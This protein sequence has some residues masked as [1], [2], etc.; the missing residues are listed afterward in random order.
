MN[1]HPRYSKS[2]KKRNRKALSRSRLASAELQYGELEAKLPLDATFAHNTDSDVLTVSGFTPDE[3]VFV[4]R[5][6]DNLVF[7]LGNGVFTTPTAE[8]DEVMIDGGTLTV[9][10]NNVGDVNI[11]ELSSTSVLTFGGNSDFGG[12]E[13]TIN[14]L[15]GYSVEQFG[16]GGN[17]SGFA[18]GELTISSSL[19]DDGSPGA[20]PGSIINLF[21]NRNR[22]DTVSATGISSFNYASDQSFTLDTLSTVGTGLQIDVEGN[23]VNDGT[24]FIST[25]DNNDLTIESVNG[26]GALT[27]DI[28]G[29]LG[30]DS[31]LDVETLT[32]FVDGDVTRDVRDNSLVAN[33]LFFDVDGSIAVENL[34]VA[35]ISGIV[36]G[37]FTITDSDNNFTNLTDTTITADFFPGLTV[38]GDLD[39]TMR[40]TSLT[41]NADAPLQLSLLD[42]I[43]DSPFLDS[44]ADAGT[45][46]FR[47]EVL[48]G[49]NSILLAESD[50]NDF[51][52]VNV[53]YLD[54]ESKG[55]F[56]DSG[57]LRLMRYNALEFSDS[58]SIVVDN[59]IANFIPTDLD[60]TGANTF[61]SRVRIS[62]GRSLPAFEDFPVLVSN[63]V[64]SITITGQ[65]EGENLLLQAP[66]IF[67]ASGA[68]ID[69]NHLF[70]G[71]DQEIEGRANFQV[72]ADSLTD[73]S[74]NAFDS[75]DVTTQQ[76]LNI[77]AG[78][79]SPATAQFV[80]T[81]LGN[82]ATGAA[83]T[84]DTLGSNFDTE[85]ALFDINGILLAQ[86]DDAGIGFFNE[87]QLTPVGLA[88]GT[89]FIALAGFSSTFGDGFSAEG[90]F[91]SG[92]YTLNLNGSPVSGNLD[93]T[94]VVFFSFNVG[95]GPTLAPPLIAANSE[96][97]TNATAG[98]FARISSTRLNFDVPF[99]TRKLSADVQTDVTQSAGAVVLIDDLQIEAKRV[100]LDNTNN[101]FERIAVIGDG[102][103]DL[104]TDGIS[105]NDE[106]VLVIRDQGTL[107]IAS[108]DNLPIDAFATTFATPAVSVVVNGISIDGT[109]DIETGYGGD[110]TNPRTGGPT[111]EQIGP[112]GRV[113]QFDLVPGRTDGVFRDDNYD[114]SVRPAYFIEFIYD[115]V[116]PLEIQ[117]DEFERRDPETVRN[118]LDIELGLYNEAG[119][120]LA[121]D[122]D[123]ANNEL[124]VLS[125]ADIDPSFLVNGNLPAGRYYVAASAFATEFEDGFVVN[126]ANNQTGTLNVTIS[127]GALFVAPEVDRDL[128]QAPDAPLIVTGGEDEGDIEDGE[129]DGSVILSA[130][131]DGEILL[132]ETDLNDVRQLVVTNAIGVE[133]T[134]ADDV[135]FVSNVANGLTFAQVSVGRA[136]AGGVLTLGDFAADEA[137]LQADSGIITN[138]ELD[139]RRLLIGGADPRDSGGDIAIIS[140]NTEELAFQFVS[141]PNN[142]LVD[143][144]GN[145]VLD[146]DGNVISLFDTDL[147]LATAQDLTVGSFEFRDS[148]IL[149]LQSRADE[150]RLQAQSL[151]VNGT[152]EAV[153][154]LVVEVDGTLT[155][156]AD[157]DTQGIIT[158]QLYFTG[159]SLDLSQSDNPIGQIS[160]ATDGDG[161]DI[162]L[163]SSVATNVAILDNQIDIGELPTSDTLNFNAANTNEGATTRSNLDFNVLRL[164]QDADSVLRGRVLTIETTGIDGILPGDDEPVDPVDPDGPIVLP[165]GPEVDNG[166]LID[167]DVDPAIAGSFAADI[168]A[169]NSA[170]FASNALTFE[171]LDGTLI[172]ND[173]I[174][175]YITY[176]QVGDTTTNLAST[177]ITQIATLI[178]D[179]VV[180]SRGTFDGPNGLVTWIATSRFDDG[181]PT[182]FSTLEFEA[183]TG[184]TLGDIQIISYL[185]EDI[186]GVGDDFLTTTGIPGQANFR[187]FTLDG[188]NRVGFSHGG[189]YSNDGTNQI[190]ATYDG[191]AADQ[192]NEL[193]NQIITNTQ[194]F[195]IGGTIDLTDL[196]VLDDPDFS[197]A[198]G[199][200]DVTT[201]FSWSTVAD[202]ANST[203]TTF[204]EFLPTVEATQPVD[205]VD[206]VDPEVVGDIIL[207]QNN[208]ISQLIIPTAFEVTFNNDRQFTALEVDARSTID[209]SSQAGDIV[210]ETINTPFF[211]TLDAAD[212]VRDTAPLDG[213]RIN[214]ATLTVNAG[215][216]NDESVFNGVLLQTNVDSADIN[217]ASAESGEVII[218]EVSGI[219]FGEVVA[220]RGDIN[221]LA[222]GAISADRVTYNAADADNEILF[223]AGGEAS[224]VV[225]GFVDARLGDVRLF[226]TDDVFHDPA[227]ETALVRGFD[228]FTFV[229]NFTDDEN[230][231]IN[232]NTQ[233]ASVTAVVGRFTDDNPAA[234]NIVIDEVDALDVQFAKTRFG[235]IDITSGQNLVARFVQAEGV[236]VGDA[237]TL[238]TTGVGGDI[239]PDRVVSRDG[240]GAITFN[241]ADDIRDFQPGDNVMVIGSSVNLQ[242]GNNL[243][244]GF[245]GI[246]LET[247]SQQI[248]AQIL[249]TE[250]AQLALRNTGSVSITDTFVNNGSINVVN[251]NGALAAL[252]L[253]SGGEDESRIALMTAGIGA[254]IVIGSVIAAD[255]GEVALVSADDI[256]DS[257]FADDLFIEADFLVATSNNNRIDTFDGIVLDA[258]VNGVISNQPNGGENVI[259]RR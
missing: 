224:D 181:T 34:R 85:L 170:M 135:E 207:D 212:D 175:A 94:E 64:G 234:G 108:L 37:N 163:L 1:N 166:T 119:D 5:V 21:G 41:Q 191:W 179:D 147:A 86:N 13:I 82:V 3:T 169:G 204:L 226:A 56:T 31:I 137:L 178:A 111:A 7:Q 241:A 235:S 26:V 253:R 242:A 125:L 145:V 67:D 11:R 146:D 158:P 33:Q 98:E 126:T 255:G 168:G 217:I 211:V 65:I 2:A 203:V 36:D 238:T 128:T 9:E 25:D 101:D 90:G 16:S 172:S 107:Q 69:T 49:T 61:D 130:L 95:T 257:N 89:Y 109:V 103:A 157:A 223:N 55:F 68:D 246:I 259:R 104:F 44:D 214:A 79:Y 243:Q 60:Q 96:V 208:S 144:D 136:G 197:P 155:A 189:F 256:F 73:L 258:A 19:P 77:V 134:D 254:D 127:N 6:G 221:V 46:V 201:A 88:D 63:Q 27:L 22:I 59:L 141:D 159:A 199:P 192:F 216:D 132:A 240:L 93:F 78:E 121:V 165:T 193:Q 213:N 171:Q 116:S 81:D 177:T 142:V 71:G 200:N 110:V 184:T 123:D 249:G 54:A 183:E 250:F 14:G 138:G 29:S 237:V 164:T 245:N 32:L 133:F 112:T 220:G 218:R 187:A 247:R 117:S 222:G 20:I 239:V 100:V 182:L 143:E 215:N 80:A 236:D 120:L 149:L 252:D 209:L 114:G 232:L 42:R 105:N 151:T 186:Q 47:V 173:L 51:G 140:P 148:G 152:L 180:E 210:V 139:I 113:E 161:G 195:S 50:S 52:S 91:S 106:D 99:T 72:S 97:F 18:A 38:N 233:V 206:P 122:D 154:K 153:T 84:I 24:A 30:L 174:F 43:I 115:G 205:P 231:G 4:N 87:S 194:D 190:N 17:Q 229:R 66:G 76:E 176:I 202:Q 70:L 244:D 28:D 74:V 162:Q 196:P 129:P 198:F 23:I 83:V 45:A 219:D 118:V 8:D 53:E 57:V 150:I 167:N 131:A 92:S 228:L 12:A 102:F 156:T 124:D 39:W 10:A 188:P 35:E 225:V 48:D 62:A 15:V 75:F 185:D 160:A 58:D 230:S 40:F 227:A 251:T 248:S